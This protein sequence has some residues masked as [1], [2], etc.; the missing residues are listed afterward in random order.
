MTTPIGV[1]LLRRKRQFIAVYS[2]TYL[3]P[4]IEFL[5]HRRKNL[6]ASVIKVFGGAGEMVGKDPMHPDSY[7]EG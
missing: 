7:L 4:L 2:N 5:R 1:E 3:L 6:S